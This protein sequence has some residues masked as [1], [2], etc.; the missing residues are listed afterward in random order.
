MPY[1]DETLKALYG[2]VKPV[3]FEF[4]NKDNEALPVNVGVTFAAQV[5]DADHLLATYTDSDFDKA[6]AAS[7]YVELL[8]SC[9]APGTWKLVLIPTFS[10]GLIDK[11]ISM[12]EIEYEGAPTVTATMTVVLSNLKISATGSG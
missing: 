5:Y 3:R 8:V 10:S 6:G 9:L 1:A 2:E 7:G 12:L 4:F 11:A